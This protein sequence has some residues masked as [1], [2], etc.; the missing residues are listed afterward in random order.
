MQTLFLLIL[1]S[2]LAHRNDSLSASRTGL[3]SGFKTPIVMSLAHWLIQE[4]IL[5]TQ[6]PHGPLYFGD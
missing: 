6:A 2:F 5:K 3:S 1:Q 4:K